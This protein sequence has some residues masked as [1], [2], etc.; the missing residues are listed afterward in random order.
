M[1]LYTYWKY[2]CL[3]SSQETTNIFI[4]ILNVE[5]NNPDFT[6]WIPLIYLQRSWDK[7]NNSNNL[8]Y[9]IVSHLPHCFTFTSKL[10]PME[11]K[12]L[13]QCQDNSTP[14]PEASWCWAPMLQP[15]KPLGKS[16]SAH[17]RER[18]VYYYQSEDNL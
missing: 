10:T 11:K 14:L 5:Y 7:R 6:I 13:W 12:G 8:I 15:A 18:L 17:T 9:L 2:Y 1:F 3:N 16:G 4:I